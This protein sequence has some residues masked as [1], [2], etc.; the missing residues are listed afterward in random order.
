MTYLLDTCAISALRGTIPPHIRTW[1]SDKKRDQFFVSVVTLAEIEDGIERLPDSKKKKDLRE[2]LNGPLYNQFAG[3]FIPIDEAIAIAWGQLN[4]RLTKNGYNVYAQDIYLAATAE[5]HKLEIVTL[6][7]KD[8]KHT[9]VTI[10]NP[11]N[12]D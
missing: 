4:A 12:Q 6:N 7:V 2:W 8:F 1:F 11:W 9:G 10:I 5:V 3:R